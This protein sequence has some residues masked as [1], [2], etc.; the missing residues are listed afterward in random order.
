MRHAPLFE[1]LRY[2][3]TFIRV[4]V[5]VVRL[6]PKTEG[7]REK[8]VKVV[9]EERERER[10]RGGESTMEKFER[11]T[12]LSKHRLI[13]SMCKKRTAATAASLT[14]ELRRAR[15]KCHNTQAEAWKLKLATLRQNARERASEG[16]QKEQ[17]STEPEREIFPSSAGEH[18]RGN[19][20]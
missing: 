18:E 5:R 4:A 6:L 15:K 8:E 10:E 19:Y 7:M 14:L 2:D 20:L 16:A 11:V 13:L 9:G 17:A 12:R 1:T 3:N